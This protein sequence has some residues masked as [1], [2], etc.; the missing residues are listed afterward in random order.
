V[1]PPVPHGSL[2]CPLIGFGRVELTSDRYRP[3]ARRLTPRNIWRA[4]TKSAGTRAA[5]YTAP[6]MNCY[7]LA[8]PWRATILASR[9]P[10]ARARS[11]SPGSRW[12]F[13]STRLLSGGTTTVSP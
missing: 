6:V 9:A 8:A 1:S 5:Q 3:S 10:Q 2:W 7:S 12:L 11:V 13:Q 4:V